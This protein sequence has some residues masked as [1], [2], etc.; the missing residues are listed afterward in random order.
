MRQT[1]FPFTYCSS[2]FQNGYLKYSMNRF[3]FAEA[4]T[5]GFS[6]AFCQYNKIGACWGM[7]TLHIISGGGSTQFSNL[8]TH[9]GATYLLM[10][11]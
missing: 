6:Q 3:Q 4:L 10:C 2:S 7:A 9:T 11:L 1:E 8:S 5:G